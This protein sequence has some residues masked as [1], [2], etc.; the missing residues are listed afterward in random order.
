MERPDNISE[1]VWNELSEYEKI[2]IYFQDEKDKIF[3][4]AGFKDCNTYTMDELVE[5]LD[6]KWMYISNV[7]S[8]GIHKLIEFYKQHKEEHKEE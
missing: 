3:K 2:E 8:F 5:Y 6:K 1:D 4:N 7:D